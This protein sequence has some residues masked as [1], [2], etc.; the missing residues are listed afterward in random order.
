MRN[1]LNKAR[2]FHCLVLVC[3]PNSNILRK[4]TDD[5]FKDDVHLFV[6]LKRLSRKGKADMFILG[7]T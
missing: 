5:D 6:V 1:N 3:K 7:P 2:V 4:L